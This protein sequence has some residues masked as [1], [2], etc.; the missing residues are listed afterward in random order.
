[1]VVLREFVTCRE[2]VI[3]K[4]KSIRWTVSILCALLVLSTI[5]TQPDPPAVSPSTTL[6]KILPSHD[7]ACETILGDESLR[8]TYPLPV[9]VIAMVASKPSRP[10]DRL[11]MTGQASDP[12]PP[13][14]VRS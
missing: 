6:C 12:S 8:P 10:S 5:D 11:V 2:F 3:W 7:F 4:M 9:S 1:L 14:P 13:G